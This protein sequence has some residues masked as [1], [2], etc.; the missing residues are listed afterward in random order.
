MRMKRSQVRLYGSLSILASTIILAVL[1]TGCGSSGPVG[2]AV[3]ATHNPLVAQYNVALTGAAQVW[4][5]FGPN[6]NYG[7]QTSQYSYAGP[8]VGTVPILVAGMQASTAYHMRA[9]AQWASGNT[10]VDEDHVF[11]T[12]PLPTSSVLAA[13]AGVPSAAFPSFNASRSSVPGSS[14]APG[15]ELFSFG[16][17]PTVVTDLNGNIIW[18]CSLAAV[19]IKLLPNGHIFLNIGT[20]LREVDLTCATVR[21]VSY[22]QVNQSLQAGGY[23]FTIPPPLGLGGGNPFH[24]DMLALPNGHWIALCQIAKDFDNLQGISGTTQVVGDALVDIDPNGNVVWA[25]SSF[26]HL[27][28]NRHPYFG[29]PDW[30][31]SNALVYTPDGNLLLSMRAQSWILKIDYANG[32]GTGDVLWRLGESGDFTIAGGDPSEWFYAQHYPSLVTTNGSV[33]TMAVYDDGNYRTY[34]NGMVCAAPLAPACFSR[35][36]IFQVDESTMLATLLWQDLPG[37]YSFWGGSIGV[38][39]NG[40]VEFDNTDPFNAASS[41]IMEVTQ[42]SNPQVVWQLN[43]AGQNAYRGFRIPSLYPGVT[44]TQ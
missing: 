27:D 22:T 17:P 36:T 35:A 2:S 16:V 13:A 19:P 33:T 6:T 25:W 37:F 32:T 15:V 11:T 41:Q 9:H 20:D 7:R 34:S 30:T 39:S 5:E 21:D 43:V 3:L 23:D 1:T 12:G 42:T 14:P 4:V 28:V 31:H 10:W 40:N 18:Y 44:W 38:L 29:L 8:G 24:H 26:D